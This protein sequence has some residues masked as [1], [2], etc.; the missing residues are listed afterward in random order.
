MSIDE[1]LKQVTPEVYE[2]M[3]RA[4]EVGKWPD[5]RLLTAAQKENCLQLI[6]AWD[7][8]HLPPEE[9]TGFLPPKPKGSPKRSETRPL[10][11]LDDGGKIH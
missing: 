3:K 7:E 11:V 8:K 4:V 1:L 6:I 10:R 5:G 2:R 9:R